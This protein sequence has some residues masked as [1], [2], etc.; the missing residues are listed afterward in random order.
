[1]AHSWSTKRC[2]NTNND[3]MSNNV[4]TKELHLMLVLVGHGNYSICVV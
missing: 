1:M 2:T 4:G 3:R